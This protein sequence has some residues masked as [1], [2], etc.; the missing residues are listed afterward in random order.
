[1]NILTKLHGTDIKDKKMN[2]EAFL[3]GLEVRI[4]L[5][6]PSCDWLKNSS[7]VHNQ[8]NQSEIRCQNYKPITYSTSNKVKEKTWLLLL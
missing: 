5:N 8:I 3:N 1:M 7:T 2:N 6:Q 4:S